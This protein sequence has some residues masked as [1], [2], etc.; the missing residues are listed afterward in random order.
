MLQASH[1]V[2]EAMYQVRFPVD[3]TLSPETIR[4]IQA[5]LGTDDAWQV[6]VEP[7]GFSLKTRGYR[8][9]GEIAERLHRLSESTLAH[10]AQTATNNVLLTYSNALPVEPPKIKHLLAE[11]VIAFLSDME[12]EFTQ[13]LH[14]T[15]S[16]GHYSLNFGVHPLGAE[17]FRPKAPHKIYLSSAYVTAE[18][19]A[20]DN[21]GDV[22]RDL[23]R[24]CLRLL[25]CP[26]A[27][28][29]LE[30]LDLASYLQVKGGTNALEG[31]AQERAALLARKYG[32]QEFSASDESRLEALT[33]RVR[34]LLPRVAAMDWQT[35]E[36]ISSRLDEAEKHTRQIQ[37]KYGL[38]G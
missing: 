26:I 4:T 27:P 24:E 14:G 32:H 37:E 17:H 38:A 1:L 19:V 36:D 35:L 16:R 8:E 18:N 21:L 5:S 22:L 13:E 28:G 20:T 25:S 3:T 33:E 34:S 15:W 2:G 11:R 10:L 30:T 12:D 6:E 23:D 31:I 29:A 7:S 9:I